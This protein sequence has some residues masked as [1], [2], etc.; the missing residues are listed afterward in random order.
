MPVFHTPFR[1]LLFALAVA[2]G[3]FAATGAAPAGTLFPDP[4]IGDGVRYNQADWATVMYPVNIGNHWAHVNQQ[5]VLVTRPDYDWSDYSYN[6]L[7]RIIM[8]RRTGYIDRNG[9]WIIDPVYLWADRF[10]E[11]FARVREGNRY[12]Y[13]DAQGKTV[14]PPIYEQALRFHEGLAAVMRDGQIGYIDGQGRSVIPPQFTRARSFSE[15]MAV[16]ETTTGRNGPSR[17]GFIDR[18]G[19]M[20]FDATAAGY[21]AI[22][23]FHSGFAA[24]L[25][26]GRWGMLNRQFEVAIEPTY[27]DIGEMH[28]GRAAVKQDGKWGYIDRDGKVVIEPTY[29]EAGDFSEVLA[30]VKLDGKYGYIDRE[31]KEVIEPQFD[32]A[33]PYFRDYARVA[34]PPNFGYIDIRGQVMWDPRAPRDGIFDLTRIRANGEA[35]R[36]PLPPARQPAVK[37]YPP[38][39]RYVPQ[40]PM[41]E[42]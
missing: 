6:G 41:E 39:S 34:Q 30:L 13:I 2:V 1:R 37:P 31:G 26:D 21:A 25:V 42:Q 9:Q 40:L 36:I 8:D 11:S 4:Y 3:P 24:F 7:A 10:T 16:A 12:G 35:P 5:G 18:N 20:V 22:A 29:D 14:T 38:E 32:S 23:D 28:G 33:E 19:E 17:L 27:E 15:G